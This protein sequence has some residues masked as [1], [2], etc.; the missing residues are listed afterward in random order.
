MPCFVAL[1]VMVT[2]A[3]TYN[4]RKLDHKNEKVPVKPK[5]SCNSDSWT[6]AVI[7]SFHF[8]NSVASENLLMLLIESNK[9]DN[10]V[11]SYRNQ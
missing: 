11:K 1:S 8:L 6:T 9:K 10:P 2:W 4:A 5:N 7:F 3:E